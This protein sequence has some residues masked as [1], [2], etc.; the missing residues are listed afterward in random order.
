LLDELAGDDGKGTSMKIGI[1]GIGMVG[2]TL[3]YGFER[4]GHDV[5]AHDIKWPTKLESLLETEILFVC[6]PTPNNSKGCDT[7]Q[8]E[9]VCLELNL[10]HYR[11]LIVIKSTVTPETTDAMI[12]YYEELHIAFCPEFLRERSRFSDFVENHDICI[13]GAH[14][15][16]YF[17]LIERAHGSLP[18][19][20]IRLKPL[21]AELAKYFCNTFNAMRIT[22][23][24]QFYEVCEKAGAD[25]T[26]IKNAVVQRPS[27]GDHY[28]EC[29]KRFRAF[30]GNCLPKDTRAFL[31]YAQDIGADPYLFETI[32]VLNEKLTSR[33]NVKVA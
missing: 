23:A 22:F 9:R 25:Y 30:G 20:F 1:V 33:K 2:E 27:I 7:S 29:N 6:V 21:E 19:R 32:M 14:R 31:R 8:V 5:Y 4:I 3:Q 24:N 10:L 15:P 13:M 12:A 11:G 16:E 18:K 26:A 28:L 17:E